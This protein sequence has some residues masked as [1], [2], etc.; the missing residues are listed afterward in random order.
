MIIRFLFVFL[1]V[2]YIQSGFGQQSFAPEELDEFV[3]AYMTFKKEKQ[4]N[5]S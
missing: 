1:F 5:D 3:S 2:A 4:R